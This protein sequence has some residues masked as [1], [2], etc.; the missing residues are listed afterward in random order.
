MLFFL[1]ILPLFFDFIAKKFNDDY[2]L[3]IP[4]SIILWPVAIFV[5]PCIYIA[6]KAWGLYI[7]YLQK[8]REIVSRLMK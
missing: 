4:I 8:G 7:V 1:A 3:M 6:N 5:I 2:E